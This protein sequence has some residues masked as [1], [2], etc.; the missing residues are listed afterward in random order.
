MVN[1]TPL[2][3]SMARESHVDLSKVQGTGVGGRITTGDVR[4]AAARLGRV[5]PAAAV[6]RPSR[7]LVVSIY[8]GLTSSNVDVDVYGP[9]PELAALQ[10]AEPDRYRAAL[11]ANGTPPTMF[12]T[13]DLPLFT[14]SGL[15]AETLLVVP[16][17]VRPTLASTADRAVARQLV[18]A[19]GGPP[20]QELWDETRQF[21]LE[22]G[23]INYVSRLFTWASAG[24]P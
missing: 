11:R 7:S 6:A 1:V 5:R 23:V 19:Y 3:A 10:S 15:E 14:A 13:G 9:N 17:V 18:E 12:A 20:S 24:T 2:V 4:A 21:W 16:Y 22:A 8:S